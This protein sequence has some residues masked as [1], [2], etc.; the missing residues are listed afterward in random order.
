MTQG[1]GEFGKI[2]EQLEF[3]LRKLRDSRDKSQQQIKNLSQ[4]LTTV[5]REEMKLRGEFADLRKQEDK[6]LK[7]RDVMK[8]KINSLNL[9]IKKLASAKQK[10]QKI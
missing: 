3:G 7:K 4:R 1:I 5:I 8:K 9:E 6:L 10:L 2:L